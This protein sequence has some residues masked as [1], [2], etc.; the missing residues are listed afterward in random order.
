MTMDAQICICP[1]TFP[2]IC[3]FLESMDFAKVASRSVKTTTWGGPIFIKSQHFPTLE[4]H[5]FQSRKLIPKPKSIFWFSWNPWNFIRI[6]SKSI[7]CSTGGGPVFN[8]FQHFPT[9]GATWNGA[10]HAYSQTKLDFLWPPWR[11]QKITKTHLGLL[12]AI[13]FAFPRRPRIQ[14]NE[15]VPPLNLMNIADF[16]FR[17]IPESSILI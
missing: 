16:E 6:A 3:D 9:K 4:R 15:S 11:P 1:Y 12:Y 10:K 13:H 17:E 5:V 14:E 2:S 7:E 8:D